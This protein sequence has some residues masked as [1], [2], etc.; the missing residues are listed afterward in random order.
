MTG[1]AQFRAR[2]RQSSYRDNT[3]CPVIGS[4]MHVQFVWLQRHKCS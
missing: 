4:R 1:W 3:G 2:Y